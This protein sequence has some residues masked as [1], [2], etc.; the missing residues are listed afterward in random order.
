M[1]VIEQELDKFTAILLGAGVSTRMI[2][3]DGKPKWMLEIN[4]QSLVQHTLNVLNREMVTKNTVLVG[5]NGGS[6]LNPSTL[7]RRTYNNTNMLTTLFSVDD[8]LVGDLIVS[9]CDVMFE[10]DVLRKL[11]R[12]DSDLAVVVDS[13]WL[14]YYKDRFL[15]WR[16]DAESCRIKKS[17]T[18]T[19]LL[20]IGQPLN[21]GEIPDAQYI[22]LLKF[23]TRGIEIAKDLY[24][25]LFREYSGKAWRNAPIFESAFMTDFVQELLETRGFIV[26][27]VVIEGGW[28]EFD[29]DKDY[30]IS[31]RE[32]QSY[33]SFNALPE[34]PVVIASGGIVKSNIDG[35]PHVLLV[36]TGIDNEWRIPKGI[37]EPGETIMECTVR[38]LREETGYHAECIDY[39]GTAEWMYK[40][41]EHTW[42]K[43][44]HFFAMSL[45]NNSVEK[46][47]EEHEAIRWFDLESAKNQLKFKEEVEVL[48][49]LTEYFQND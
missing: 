9:Y 29:T 8:L 19:E 4:G 32:K 2:I 14:E 25:D 20:D 12:S 34:N 45:V 11:M 44:T 35:L 41:E 28:L 21:V 17:K 15:D 31:K 10:P 49:R 13:K 42:Q 6:V 18:K 1:H 47:D 39:L 23:S 37:L 36:G 38:E 26:E 46:S 40:Y 27:P 3:A 43:L 33:L 16:D 30:E 48:N 7:I 5:P 22:G 24:R